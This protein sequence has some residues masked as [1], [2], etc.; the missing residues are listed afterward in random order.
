MSSWKTSLRNKSIRRLD[1]SADLGGTA[2]IALLG[3]ITT[4]LDDLTFFGFNDD[5]WH[6]AAPR[7]IPFH[8]PQW[9][10]HRRTLLP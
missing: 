4:V 7:N 3:N 9:A 6:E 5:N 10:I 8:Q 2:M 1:V